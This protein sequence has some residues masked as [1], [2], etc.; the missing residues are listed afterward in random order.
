MEPYKPWRDKSRRTE[1]EIN[2]EILASHKKE[3]L[4][5]PDDTK[6]IVLRAGS[7]SDH[8]DF[9]VPEGVARCSGLIKSI[10]DS[11]GNFLEQQTRIVH[12]VDIQPQ[13]LKDVISFCSQELQ[14]NPNQNSP[15]KV[16]F[17]FQI[18]PDS[19]M[20]IL[21]AAHYLQ[22]PSLT[23][24]ATSMLADFA[25]DVPSFEGIFPEVV[26]EVCI[27]C[28]PSM[29]RVIE[30]QNKLEGFNV[31]TMSIWKRWCERKKWVDVVVARQKD[32]GSCDDA[33]TKEFE[34]KIDWCRGYAETALSIMLTKIGMFVSQEEFIDFLITFG[35]IIQ[36]VRIDSSWNFE[37]MKFDNILIDYIPNL[38]WLDLSRDLNSVEDL[39]LPIARRLCAVLHHFNK[40][41]THLKLTGCNITNKLIADLTSSIRGCEDLRHLDLSENLLSEEG[42]KELAGNLL[43]YVGLQYPKN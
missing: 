6:K 32:C 40:G 30:K 41:L 22:I 29:L 11:P 20:D 25:V 12:L 8:V 31:D 39:S 34:D 38:R 1:E 23:G 7:E 4:K 3:T 2:F 24:Y 18:T 36:Y 17:V 14:E 19:V 21:S 5:A 10:L 15:S 35:D 16:V 42:M 26:H 37:Y 13:I 43:P 28:K 33:T 9:T 27:K